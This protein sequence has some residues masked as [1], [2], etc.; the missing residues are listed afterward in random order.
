MQNI[1]PKHT[2]SVTG[3]MW[4]RENWEEISLEFNG[5]VVNMDGEEYLESTHRVLNCE[6]GQLSVLTNHGELFVDEGDWIVRRWDGID[7]ISSDL[8]EQAYT[9]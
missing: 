8:F 9:L 5:E 6:D 7:V 1:Y 3:I 4:N 2:D